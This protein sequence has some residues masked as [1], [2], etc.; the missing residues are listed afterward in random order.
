M[1][2]WRKLNQDDQA[3]LLAW[4][5][6]LNRPWHSPPHFVE[7]PGRFHLTAACYEHA[8]IVGASTERM[9]TFSVDLLRTL[10]EAGAETHAWCVLPNHY[11]LLVD[12]PDLKQVMSALGQ[13]H[14]R[15]SFAWNGEDGQRG[16]KVWCAPADREI[17]GDAHFWATLNYIHHNPV[18]HG[19]A[20]GWQDWPY[21][22]ASDYLAAVGR[23]E[24]VRVWKSYPVLDYGA[25]W[26]D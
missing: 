21:S 23:E 13:L 12:V 26:D 3:T 6:Q 19:W 24:A 9:G 18:K 8:E 5:Q 17:R 16:R 1:Y 2:R 14:G 4:R 25:G 10:D 20:K 15:C 7:G 11:H 22:S